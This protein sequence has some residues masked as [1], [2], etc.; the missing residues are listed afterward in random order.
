MKAWFIVGLSAVCA[1]SFAQ[2]NDN[3]EGETGSAGGTLL[4]NGFGG[5]GQNGW[6]NPVS[7]SIDSNVF[8]Y[9]GN[10]LGFSNNPNGGTKFVGMD[11]TVAQTPNRAQHDLTYGS[12]VWTMSYDFNGNF[13]G[14]PPAAD[15]LGSVSLQPST[16][17]NAFQTI[18]Q[19][20]NPIDHS[21]LA[22]AYNANIGW[23]SSAGS[24]GGA[25]T[26]SSPGVA[27]QSLNLNHWYHMSV[28]W[29]FTTNQILSASIND[30]SAGGSTTTY[31][32]SGNGWYLSGGANNVLGQAAPT[33]IRLFGSGSAGDLMGYDNLSVGPVPEP[34]SMAV[35]GI[36]ALALLRKRRNR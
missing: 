28:S 22:D 20:T 8:T 9:A 7:G 23:A 17:N 34:A 29:N 16:T 10:A 31:D 32:V 14:T 24:T 2:F 5:G 19:W 25:F 13:N 12:G 6:Y 26:F 27:F 15:N 1:M 4:T 3:F 36:G 11:V 21:A 33:G 30:I 18:F 35:L